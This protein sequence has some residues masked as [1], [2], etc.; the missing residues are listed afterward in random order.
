VPTRVS[1]LHEPP[2]GRFPSFIQDIS[3][4]TQ[5]LH[6]HS[7]SQASSVMPSHKF[8]GKY[9]TAR[10]L[11]QSH[12]PLHFLLHCQC[13]ALRTGHYVITVCPF[14]RPEGGSSFLFPTPCLSES[15]AI[16]RH[17]QYKGRGPLW[18][19]LATRAVSACLRP[20]PR[21]SP[22]SGRMLGSTPGRSQLAHTS[23][24]KCSPESITGVHRMRNCLSACHNKSLS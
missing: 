20:M 14:R 1:R 21:P 22:I 3:G 16:L 19:F 6:G 18:H 23:P 4:S 7:P 11:P 2:S 17:F 5:L 15:P 24:Y 8:D 10:F 13:G 12:D 9:Y